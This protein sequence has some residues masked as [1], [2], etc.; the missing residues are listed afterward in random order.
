MDLDLLE[1][2]SD[3]E[4]VGKTRAKEPRPLFFDILTVE[5]AVLETDT[6]TLQT[7]RRCAEELWK[8]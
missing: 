4:D 2:F 1:G 8:V 7:V 6:S 5:R 3:D